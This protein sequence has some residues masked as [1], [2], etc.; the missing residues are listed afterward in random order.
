MTDGRSLA[1][2]DYCY[3]TTTGRHSGEPHRIEIWFALVDGVVYLLSGGGDRSDWVRNL[4][5]SPDVVLEIGGE[6]RTTKAWVVTDLEEDALARSVIREKYR[7]R[8]RGDLDDW[9]RMS[10]PVAIDWR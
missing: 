1:D 3:L 7:P 8:Y 9:G 2:L 6:K 10:L 4:Q 5:V